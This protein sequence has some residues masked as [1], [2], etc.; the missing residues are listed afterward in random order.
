[1]LR[2]TEAEE[3]RASTCVGA[4]PSAANSGPSVAASRQPNCREP[5]AA[6][7]RP[8]SSQRPLSGWKGT[9]ALVSTQT[10][11]PAFLP[12]PSAQ[13]LSSMLIWRQHSRTLGER[14][15]LRFGGTKSRTVG[16]PS[17]WHM[18]CKARTLPAVA[19]GLWCFRSLV[20]AMS[21]ARLKGPCSRKMCRRP[22]PTRPAESRTWGVSA[23]WTICL[24]LR[25]L[26]PQVK[27][28]ADT[29]LPRL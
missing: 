13:S 5:G 4:A 17:R 18:A 28:S 23:C 14:D 20:P 16:T 1:M 19:S 21:S 27:T 25:P 2:E 24:A 29:L 8:S 7:C 11:T 12:G 6:K 15:V 26:R 22:Q 10:A 9:S 3:R